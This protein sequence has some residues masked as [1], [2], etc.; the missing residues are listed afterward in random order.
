MAAPRPEPTDSYFLL[1]GSG[2]LHRHFPGIEL[3]TV[4]G[5]ALM[6]SVVTF[7]PDAEVPDH[8]HPHEQMGFLVSGTLEFTIGGLTRTLH[9]GDLWRIPGGIP[10]RV[11]ARGGPAVA[12]DCFHPIREDY[13]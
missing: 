4:A 5:E 3:R 11:V 12:L 2:S 13:L 10:H 8:A 1:A 6:L 9:A 7:E